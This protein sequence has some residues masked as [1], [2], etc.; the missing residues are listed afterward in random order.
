[1]LLNMCIATPQPNPILTLRYAH[2]HPAKKGAN[3]VTSAYGSNIQLKLLKAHRWTS[4]NAMEVTHIAGICQVVFFLCQN[5]SFVAK[6]MQ[7][8][9]AIAIQNEIVQNRGVADLLC[10]KAGNKAIQARLTPTAIFRNDRPNRNNNSS[11]TGAIKAVIR[12]ARIKPLEDSVTVGSPPKFVNSLGLMPYFSYTNIHTPI[13][14]I[15]MMRE[16]SQN[17]NA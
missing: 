2:E 15:I 5:S 11:N 4:P 7:Q 1:M 13:I 6:Y 3:D 8:N 9:T 16:I 10:E 17:K 14:T 12:T